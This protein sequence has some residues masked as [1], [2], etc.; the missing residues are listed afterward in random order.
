MRTRVKIT[1]E[2]VPLAYQGNTALVEAYQNGWLIAA[3]SEDNAKW[4]M[5]IETY[6][7]GFRQDPNWLRVVWKEIID[8]YKQDVSFKS[9]A[10]SQ[11]FDAGAHDAIE[12]GVAAHFK[13][14]Y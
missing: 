9:A 2:K 6:L 4:K 14:V 1:P 5:D 8:K 7:L 3:M 11:A 10:E 13:G 12:H